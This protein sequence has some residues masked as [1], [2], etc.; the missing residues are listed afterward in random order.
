MK[1]ILPFLLLF[2][3]LLLAGCSSGGQSTC[4]FTG[5]TP[6]GTYLV[7]FTNTVDGSTFTITRVASSSGTISI[8]TNGSCAN[9]VVLEVTTANVALSASPSAIDLQNP[10]ATATITGQAF[11]TTY[12]MPR[13]EYFDSTGFLVGSATATSVWGGGTALQCY[14]PNLAQ[15]YSGTYTIR[16]T[17][18]TSSGYYTHRVGTAT[19]TA[20][21]RDR[22]D[23]D[24]DGFYDDEDCDP[25][26]PYNYSCQTCGGTG[27]EPLTFCPPL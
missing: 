22:V 3:V 9:V 16:V 11:D 20:Y 25:W 10:P 14:V 23:S 4:N 8:T 7:V 5:L 24:G 6:N 2:V 15:A 12:G 17:N 21:G 18:K 19:V 13:V 26:D 27:N 1:T